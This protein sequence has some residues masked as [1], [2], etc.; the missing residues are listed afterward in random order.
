[1]LEVSKEPQRKP[2][3][4]KLPSH[5]NFDPLKD[6]P[7]HNGQPMPFWFVTG[8]L[9]EIEEIHG[10]NSQNAVKEII[11]NVFRAAIAQNTNELCPLFYFF[12]VKL[13]PEYEAIE[14]NVGHEIVLKS[15]AKA[16]G[17]SAKQIREAFHKEGDMGVV[18]EIGK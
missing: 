9:A 18:I 5:E 16:C 8:A 12:I 17:K 1:M 15:V 3:D 13:A 2:E 14:T 11:A 6:S 7:H 4:I 10:K